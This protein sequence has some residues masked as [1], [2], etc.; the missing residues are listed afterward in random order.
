MS[1]SVVAPAEII[2][3]SPM[4]AL[5]TKQ[6]YA[7]GNPSLAYVDEE[8]ENPPSFSGPYEERAYLK[9]RLALA[10][11][12]F[13]R[14][15]LAEGVAGHITLRDPVDPT[16]FWVNPFGTHFSMIRDKDLIRVDHGAAFAIHAEIYKARPD[17]LCAA[18]SH[19]L[20]GRAMC[21]TGRMLDMLTQDF[22]VFYKD[23]VLHE[24][25]VG[26]VLDSN[27]GKA[28]CAALGN[29]K[30]A[31]PGNHGILTVGPTVEAT[32]AWFVL[33]ENCCQIQLMVDVA[34]AGRGVPSVTTREGEA[35]A[36]WEAVGTNG[37]G[38]FQGF[39]LFQVAEQESG[40]HTLLGRGVVAA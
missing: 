10:F 4:Q 33:L 15:G 34:A 1:P 8:A 22:Y 16:S 11:R 36:T 25:F 23:H 40:E 3:P 13:A 28:I 20:Y 17:V 26:L 6:L 29:R 35:Q 7:S 14:H 27:E 32:V 9:H 38:Y 12:V 37:N 2:D 19:S 24:N 39:P 31:L 21:A 30:S 18:H 5:Q